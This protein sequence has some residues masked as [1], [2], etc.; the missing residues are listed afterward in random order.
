MQGIRDSGIEVEFKHVHG[1]TGDE[2]NEIV[3]KLAKIGCG[4]SL[5]ASERGFIERLKSV[6]GYPE[7]QLSQDAEDEIQ[8]G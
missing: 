3:D 7:D 5:T 6:P 8:I 1:H 4:V 2:G